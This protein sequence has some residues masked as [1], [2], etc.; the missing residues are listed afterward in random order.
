MKHFADDEW[1]DWARGT[2]PEEKRSAMQSHLDSGCTECRAAQMLWS[3]LAEVSAREKSYEPPAD[4]VRAAK[5][6]FGVAGPEPKAGLIEVIK[7]VFDSFAQPVAQGVRG[8]SAARQLVSR[9]QGYCVDLQLDAQANMVSVV[10]QIVEDVEP[11]RPLANIFVSLNTGGSPQKQTRTNEFGEFHLDCAPAGAL[12]IQFAVG[13]GP[14]LE[15]PLPGMG[16]TVRS[17]MLRS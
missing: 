9:G 1:V 11:A 7:L 2:A 4:V 10:G 6:A 5:A 16:R 17:S 12:R 13:T 14:A 8:G 3:R 15:I